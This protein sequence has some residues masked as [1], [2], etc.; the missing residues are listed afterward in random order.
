MYAWITVSLAGW[1]IYCI[2]SLAPPSLRMEPTS[3]H[4]ANQ[5]FLASK[6]KQHFRVTHAIEEYF[7]DCVLA[8][9][10]PCVNACGRLGACWLARRDIR[11]VRPG[12][13]DEC[14]RVSGP[15]VY[16]SQLYSPVLE[17]ST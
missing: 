7:Y 14:E 9:F 3:P 15:R 13:H 17:C 5:P 10:R 12:A 6:P 8:T 2:Y 1:L 16:F 11:S 4:V